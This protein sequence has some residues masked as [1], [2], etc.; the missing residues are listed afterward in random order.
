MRVAWHRHRERSACDGRG[1]R[2]V[3]VA[4]VGGE[5][6]DPS[7]DRA[8]ARRVR[9]RQQPGEAMTENGA[10]GRAEAGA[11]LLDQCDDLGSLTRSW[12]LGLRWLCPVRCHRHT[13]SEGRTA[14]TTHEIYVEIRAMATTPQWVTRRHRPPRRGTGSAAGD[15]ARCAATKSARFRAQS[16]PAAGARA[17]RAGLRESAPTRGSAWDWAR[18]PA[19]TGT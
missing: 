6:L 8:P 13:A 12:P 2:L 5:L 15:R 10:V 9:V 18:R 4:V 14:Q 7:R 3:A 11:Q 19:S 1:L 16:R 17:T